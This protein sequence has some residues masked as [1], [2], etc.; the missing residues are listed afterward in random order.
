VY[1]LCVHNKVKVFAVDAIRLLSNKLCYAARSTVSFF[2]YKLLITEKHLPSPFI[3]HT[4]PNFSMYVLYDDLKWSFSQAIESIDNASVPIVA[5][6][7]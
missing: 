6:V 2:L 4:I 1:V 7:L 5:D 3:N